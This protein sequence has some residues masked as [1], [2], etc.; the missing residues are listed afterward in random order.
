MRLLRNEWFW[1]GFLFLGGMAVC[2]ALGFNG[3]YGQDAYEY[4]R[5]SAALRSALL[6]DGDAGDFFWPVN[7]P[8]LGALLSLLLGSTAIALQMISLASHALTFVLVMRILRRFAPGGA[9][10]QM[11][12]AFVAVGL[13]PILVRHAP[14][15]MADSLGMMCLTAGFWFALCHRDK[16]RPLHALLC[17]AALGMAFMT[18]YGA[19]VPA[20]VPALMVAVQMLRRRQWVLIAAT[21]LMAGG[22]LLPHLLLRSDAPV[23][24]AGHAWLTGWHP[25]NFVRRDFVTPD[26]D[27]HFGVPNLVF[28]L[29]AIGHPGYC[30]I[31][32]ALL[33]FVRKR[34]LM[35]KAWQVLALGALIYLLFLGGIPYQNIRFLSLGF[36]LVAAVLW[37]PLH[38]VMERWLKGV[39][40][41]WV[42]LVLGVCCQLALSALALRPMARHVKL[43]REVA[44]ALAE[45]PKGKLFTFS[46]EGM[47]RYQG[48]EQ[49]VVSIFEQ[50][51]KDCGE[52]ALL[53]QPEVVTTQWKGKN[54]EKNWLFFKSNC[55]VVLVKEFDKGWGLYLVRSVE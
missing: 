48:I 15:V 21:L 38:R 12:F 13:S 40:W 4:E 49:E 25:L 22:V 1:A 17:A 43:E 7:Y 30:L 19:A 24:F 23:A 33:L 46:W 28:V 20:V 14:L 52:G 31:G 5:F 53:I 26:G 36:P 29:Y 51:V 54:P 41:Q 42:T 10:A 18:R 39:T 44:A 8:L 47:I 2:W 37:W 32:F 50:E 3:L 45:L 35:D 9:M 16:G 11:A 27:L 6:G 55:V 34:D